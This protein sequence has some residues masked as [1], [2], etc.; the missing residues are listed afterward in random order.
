MVGDNLKFILSLLN[1]NFI[2]RSFYKYYS[3]GGIEGEIK[4][5]KLERLPL[6]DLTNEEMKPFIQ[7][8]DQILSITKDDDYL[9][10]S[11][12]QSKVKRLEKE[13]DQLV[14]KLYELTPEEIKIVEE[15]N[16]K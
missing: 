5:D 14:Y 2:Y 13:I 15:F 9:D 6:P 8:V 7:L 10:N 3:G 4:I 1:T 16:K 12:K 11:D